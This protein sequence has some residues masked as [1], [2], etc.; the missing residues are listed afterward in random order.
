MERDPLPT[1]KQKQALC[2][3]MQAAFVE[4]RI[5]DGE[6][7]H[8]LANAFHNMPRE[9]YGWGTWS[10]ARTRTALQNYQLK[11]NDNLGVNYV[12]LFNAIYPAQ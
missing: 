11:H 4:L 7:A 1:E 3:L 10:V 12:E 6:Q 9:M 8:D 5:L 2:E